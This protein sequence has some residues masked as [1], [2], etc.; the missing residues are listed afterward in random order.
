MSILC[1]ICARGNSKGLKNKNIKLLNGKP[2]VSI[3]INQALRSKLFDKII[4]STDS[5]KIKSISVKYGA[6]YLSLRKKKL[7]LDGTPK[8]DVIKD[9]C[10]EAEKK[11]KKK[12]DY[13]CDLD[14]T[15]P[16]RTILDIKNSFNIFLKSGSDNLLSICDARKNPYFNMIEIK[17]GYVQRVISS[18]KIINSR[19]KAP[20]VYEM[21]ASIYIWKRDI[22][23]SS[24]PLFRKKTFLYKMPFE[25]SIDIDSASD[26]KLVKLLS[27][28]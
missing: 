6:S 21:N 1:T 20:K 10:L 25:R 26:W 13:I 2:L 9:V 22:L 8:I 16:L 11:Y 24:S 5:P 3:S 19:Q 17:N 28:K 27:K 15:S 7:S 4:I 12:F 23:F 14:I 18:K